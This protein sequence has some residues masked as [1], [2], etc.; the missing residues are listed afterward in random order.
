M[1]A[2]V[3]VPTAGVVITAVAISVLLITEVGKEV[4]VAVLVVVVAATIQAGSSIN[5]QTPSESNVH[6]V[7]ERYDPEFFQTCSTCPCGA[8]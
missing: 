4:G 1:A 7:F 6:A 3:A 8:F 2:A 5:P